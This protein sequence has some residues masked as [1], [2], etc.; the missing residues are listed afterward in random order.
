MLRYKGKQ[1]FHYLKKIVQFN[2][3]GRVADFNVQNQKSLAGTR[4]TL[5]CYE[6]RKTLQP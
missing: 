2:Q 6:K 4:S 3:E 1:M 5:Y